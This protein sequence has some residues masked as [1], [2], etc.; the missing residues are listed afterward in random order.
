M[1]MYKAKWP[2]AT[3]TTNTTN[4]TNKDAGDLGRARTCV[5]YRNGL[6]RLAQL[7]AAPSLRST[8]S[9]AA[10]IA[11]TPSTRPFYPFPLFTRCAV[12]FCATR[13]NCPD[14]SS[15]HPSELRVID[16]PAARQKESRR[17]PPQLHPPHTANVTFCPPCQSTPR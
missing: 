13:P 3:K 6:A 1:Y 15:K 11:T 12:L 17:K 2:M 7:T 10:S 14:T 16:S 8:A 4:A 9:V 5:L